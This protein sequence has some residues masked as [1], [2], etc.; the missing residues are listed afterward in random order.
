MKV[1][2][3]MGMVKT[4]KDDRPVDELSIL[5]ANVVEGA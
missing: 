5:K 1:I 4:D 3:R 2:Q